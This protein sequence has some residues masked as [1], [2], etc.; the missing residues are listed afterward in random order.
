MNLL[1]VYLIVINIS[2]FNEGIVSIS[3]IIHH[4]NNDD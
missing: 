2:V 3:V 1:H 4:S